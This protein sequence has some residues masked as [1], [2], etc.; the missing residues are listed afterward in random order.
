MKACVEAE[1]KMRKRIMPGS[2]GNGG[3]G[4]DPSKYR[5]V[6]TPPTEQLCRPPQ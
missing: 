4:G 2:S 6:Y 5:M 1:E 3:S